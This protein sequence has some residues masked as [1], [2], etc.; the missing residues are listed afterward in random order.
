[1][2]LVRVIPFAFS[3]SLCECSYYSQDGWATAG[4]ANVGPHYFLGA[5]PRSTPGWKDSPESPLKWMKN[6]TM[7]NADVMLSLLLGIMPDQMHAFDGNF[8]A[9][10]PLEFGGSIDL[11][12][13]TTYWVPDTATTSQFVGFISHLQ[14][15]FW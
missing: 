4:Y 12:D 13:A 6:L 3:L 11:C 2:T 9:G 1:M 7:V 8:K 15:I 10:S 14:S 5:L